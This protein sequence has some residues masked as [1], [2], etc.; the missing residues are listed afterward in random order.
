[1]G[2]HGGVAV[3]Q[4]WERGH[5]GEDILVC[6][7]TMAEFDSEKLVSKCTPLETWSMHAQ[8]LSI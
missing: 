5:G 6:G 3:G 4:D 7:H 8:T 1:M 2:V